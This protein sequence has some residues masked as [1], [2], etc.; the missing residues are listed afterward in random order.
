MWWEAEQKGWLQNFSHLVGPPQLA[1]L[2]QSFPFFSSPLPIAIPFPDCS[3]NDLFK[4]QIF[5]KFQGYLGIKFN[6]LGVADKA[7][8]DLVSAFSSYKH[9]LIF[10]GFISGVPAWN[11]P[12]CIVCLANFCLPY[13]SQVKY[14]L[15]WETLVALAMCIHCSHYFLYHSPFWMLLKSPV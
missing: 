9:I 6:P 7:L 12:P 14:C 1:I 11:D 13:M 2:Q 3:K 10:P 5:N 15:Y 8:H 4:E